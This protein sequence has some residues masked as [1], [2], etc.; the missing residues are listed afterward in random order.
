[1]SEERTKFI[2]LPVSQP[3]S[4][5]RQ[6]MLVMLQGA[7]PGQ[8]WALP[9]GGLTIGRVAPADIVIP[10]SAISRSHC[11]VEA[12]AG[13]LFV[14]DMGSTNGTRIDGRRIEG[15]TLLPVGG[16]LQ[17]DGNIFQH[18]LLSDAQLRREDERLRE[19]EAALAYV[20]AQL[21]VPTSSGPIGIDWHYVPSTDLGG[22]AF[23]AAWLPDGRFCCYLIDVSGHGAGAAMHAV[24]VMNA[25]RPQALAGIDP[26]DPA[27][28][29]A[30]LNR[31]FR[32]EDHADMYFTI[33]YGVYDPATREMGFAA[34]GHHPAFLCLP[35]FPPTAVG[36]KNRMIGTPI[37]R[38]FT[39]GRCLVPPGTTLYLFSDGVFEIV[40]ADGKAWQLADFVPLLQPGRVARLPQQYH[41]IM[42]SKLAGRRFGD[43]FTLLALHFT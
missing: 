17:L 16:L 10:D 23:G 25:L 32:M 21:P 34:A 11:R 15:R 40:D 5:D 20:K 35:G 38:P 12:D 43:D 4:D 14:T 1:L 29:L 8:R 28:V 26:G 18:D 33:W 22:D 36:T 6:H 7:S 39:A 41:A 24:A 13:Q 9:P 3:R 19:L 37:D 2:S 31:L 30:R 27:A 42:Q